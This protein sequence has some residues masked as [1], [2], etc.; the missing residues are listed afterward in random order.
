MTD[1]WNVSRCES[2]GVDYVCPESKLLLGRREVIGLAGSLFTWAFSPRIASAAG[3]QDPR[4]LIVLM[5]GGWDGLNILPNFADEN[6]A[7]RRATLAL[8]ENEQLPLSSFT[9]APDTDTHYRQYRLNAVMKNYQQI[10]EEGQARIVLPIAPPLQT[11]SHFDCS[12]NLENGSPGNAK[13]DS[14]WLNRLLQVL[15]TGHSLLSSRIPL[16][17]G[18]TPVILTGRAP[19][20]SWT[21]NSFQRNFFSNVKTVNRARV[22][23]RMYAASPLLG[24]ELRKGLTTDAM[25][26]ALDLEIPRISGSLQASMAGAARMFK[27]DGGPRVAVMTVNSFDTHIAE[28]DNTKNILSGFDAAL[29]IFRTALGGKDSAAWQQTLVVCVSEFGRSVADNG[30]GGCDHGIG[31]VALLAGGMFKKSKIIGRW[32]VLI[33]KELDKN[34]DVRANY[35]TR[36]LFKSVLTNHMGIQDVAFTRGEFSGQKLLTGVVFPDSSSRLN[37][38]LPLDDLFA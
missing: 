32:P 26:T 15:P 6:Y 29:G 18:N 3:T 22:L 1:N 10:F 24:K 7:I 36:D 25:A 4:L 28:A 33:E 16:Q 13:T 35:D 27:T 17:I 14:G 34:K 9:A 5:R 37:G 23:E 19:T 30:S 2:A 11:R 21:P 20:I 31:T 38:Y 12:F 8:T